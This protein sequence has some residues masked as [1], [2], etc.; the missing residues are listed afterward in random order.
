M[1]KNAKNPFNCTSAQEQMNGLLRPPSKVTI[2][3][4]RPRTDVNGQLMDVHDGTI[5][6]S[7]SVRNTDILKGKFCH[8]F[9]LESH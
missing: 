3:N 8:F 1:K 2:D 5:I 4:T 7:P 6:R 9:E